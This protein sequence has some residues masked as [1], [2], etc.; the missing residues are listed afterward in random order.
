LAKFR[1]DFSFAKEIS[2]N[3]VKYLFQEM[4]L[5][6]FPEISRNTFCVL[7]NFVVL[8]D[9]QKKFAKFRQIFILQNDF[10]EISQNFAKCFSYFANK[11]GLAVFLSPPGMSLT[12]LSLARKNVA[13]PSP[14]KVWSNKSRNLNKKKLQCMEYYLLNSIEI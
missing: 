2:R 3:L 5:P 8:L 12:E 10:A 1:R 9:L 11:K 6:K 13:S 4:I 7:R 14:R